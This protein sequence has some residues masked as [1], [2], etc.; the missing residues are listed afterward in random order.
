VT[1]R[2]HSPNANVV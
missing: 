1:P 2:N